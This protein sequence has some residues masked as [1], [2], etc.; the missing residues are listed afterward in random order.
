M[1]VINNIL[2][3]SEQDVK[4]VPKGKTLK[5]F[6][7]KKKFFDTRKIED[8]FYERVMKID[9]NDVRQKFE[10]KAGLKNRK[11][12]RN[13]LLRSGKKKGTTLFAIDRKIKKRRGKYV[14]PKVLTSRQFIDN[15]YKRSTAK[16]D[17]LKMYNKCRD[18]TGSR[19]SY[20]TFSHYIA[21][22]K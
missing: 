13:I 4:N 3:Y 14:K 12:R 7:P 1:Q 21:K 19:L 9:G 8:N 10:N 22:L 18:I 6:V 20:K 15:L 2:F 16:I 5:D 17:I 11:Q